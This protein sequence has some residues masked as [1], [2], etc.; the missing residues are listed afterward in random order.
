MSLLERSKSIRENL[1]ARNPYS[2]AKPYNEN[3]PNAISDGDSKGRGENAS[4]QVGTSVDIA[5][6]NKLVAKNKYRAGKEYTV[7]E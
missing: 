4:G 2:S 6:R 3:H 5:Q 7:I 1:L